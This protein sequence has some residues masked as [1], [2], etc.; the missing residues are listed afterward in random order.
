MRR[1]IPLLAALIVLLPSYGYAF[2]PT[3][4]TATTGNLAHSYTAPDEAQLN[5]HGHYRNVDGKTIH[6][7]AH[8]K[9]GQAPSG[10]TAKCG[11]GSFS[12][13]QHHRGTCS[14]HGGVDEWL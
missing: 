13:S 3:P 7:P 5:E 2:D 14:H 4:Q 1:L 10:A 8:T 12:F 11:D 6:S 9:N